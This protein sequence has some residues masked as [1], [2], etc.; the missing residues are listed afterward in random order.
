MNDMTLAQEGLQ[1]LKALLAF[2]TTNPPGNEMPA[3]E[4]LQNVLRAE[5]FEPVLIES[6]DKRGNLV[7]RLKGDGSEK[8]LLLLSHLDVVP[9]Q[10]EN[11]DLPPFAAEEKDGYLYGRGTLDMKQ[12]TAMSLMTLFS[13]KRKGLKLKR[14]IIFAAVADEEA[15]GKLGAEYLVEN[16]PELIEAEYALCE[17]GGFRLD[18]R[19][20]TFFPVQVAERG[21]AWC[22]VQFLGEPGHGSIP[23]PDSAVSKMIQALIRLE[24]KGLP[25][26]ATDTVREF[27][28][29]VA[30]KQK[31][32]VRTAMKALLS[33]LTSRMALSRL[34]QE[35]A[36][37]FYAQ[38][39]STATPTILRAGDKQNVIPGQADVI[40]DGRVLPGE[41]WESF[42]KEL[43]HVLGREAQIELIQWAE[44]LVYSSDT[45]LF[46]VIRRVVTER[47]PDAEV[48]PYLL[49]G[50]TDA[51]HL[52]KL[53]IVTYGFSPMNNDPDEKFS[54]LVHGHNE[55]IGIEAFHWGVETLTEVVERFCSIASSVKAVD[56]LMEEML[57]PEQA[58][59][60]TGSKQKDPTL[61][62]GLA[63]E[64]PEPED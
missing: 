9:A 8:P 20:H 11:W 29:A 2:D 63:A 1:H 16:N 31:T 38:L 24:K 50:F 13:A 10:A 49:T 46:D 54:R 34:E 61:P 30:A 18:V 36:R 44:P 51:K 56:A 5:G 14:D 37:V 6:A 53:G 4:Y 15:G 33:P 3:A 23:N 26:H 35:Q 43:Q 19:G 48:V 32:H 62:D 57:E 22:K 25:L 64:P 58:G 52:D 55:R 7:A 47:V 27:I 12:M 59:T 17:M 39:H 28:S 40:L 60:P 41:T 45:P 21:C 42:K